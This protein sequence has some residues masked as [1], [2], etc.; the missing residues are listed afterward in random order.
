[1]KSTGLNLRVT[2]NSLNISF[3]QEKLMALSADQL[4]GQFPIFLVGQIKIDPSQRLNIFFVQSLDIRMSLCV[5]P[6][7]E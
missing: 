7:F 2:I 6:G 1:M 5:D 3:F 4:F